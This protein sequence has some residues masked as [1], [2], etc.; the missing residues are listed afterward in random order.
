MMMQKGRVLKSAGMLAWSKATAPS[1]TSNLCI[2][3]CHS[4]K[5][6]CQFH[7]RTPLIKLEKLLMLINLNPLIHVFF[8][9]GA[10]KWKVHTKH[11]CCMLNGCLKEKY[12][13]HH[14]SWKVNYLLFSWNMFSLKRTTDKLWPFKL[15]YLADIF[16]KMTKISLSLQEKQWTICC[17]L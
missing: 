15:E 2:F 12:L 1:Y 6:K 16:S 3:Y 9:F 7:L 10:T 14:L 13:C 17:Q 8:L 11:F 5:R 4:V